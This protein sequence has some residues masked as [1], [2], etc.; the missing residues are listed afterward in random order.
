MQKVIEGSL[1]LLYVIGTLSLFMSGGGMF[2]MGMSGD[3]LLLIP[4]AIVGGIYM[5]TLKKMQELLLK[6]EK[7]KAYMIGNGV[8]WIGTFALFVQ[9]SGTMLNTH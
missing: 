6:N 7:I 2:I 9:C 1:T 5:Y 8:V 3:A 4:V